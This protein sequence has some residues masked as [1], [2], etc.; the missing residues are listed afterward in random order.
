MSEPLVSIVTPVYNTDKYLA[1]CI[2]SVLAQTYKHWE[3]LIVNNRST[4]KSLEIAESCARK[5]P[6]I[7]IHTNEEFLSLMKN[8]NHAMRLIPP[9]SRYCKVVHA[10]DW[11]FP[12]CIARMVEVAETFPSVGIVGAYRLEEDRVSLDGL[13]AKQSFFDGREICR[14][15]LMGR[16]Y[17]FGSPTSLLIRSGIIRERSPFYDE[18]TLEA[19][20]EACYEILKERDF[21]F[22]HQ[23]LTFTRRHN[24]SITAGAQRVKVPRKIPALKKFGPFFLSETEF[25]QA[26]EREFNKYYTLLA[27]GLWELRGKEFLRHHKEAFRRMGESVRWMKLSKELA[28][29]MLDLRSTFRSVKQGIIARRSGISKRQGDITSIPDLKD[30]AD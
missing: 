8:W 1:E 18:S 6:R 7:R 21:G 15:Q 13:P 20:K 10:D 27:K 25:Q 26:K 17:L 11:L 29:Q 16:P 14:G 23:V 24:E 2:E 22:V 30:P 5:E 3:Y 19:D 9:E 4:D 28:L 12:D